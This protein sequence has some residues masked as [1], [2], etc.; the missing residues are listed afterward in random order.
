VEVLGTVQPPSYSNL[1]SRPWFPDAK[2][3][4]GTTT[5]GFCRRRPLMLNRLIRQYRGC[6]NEQSKVGCL[7]E[8]VVV[9][10]GVEQFKTVRRKAA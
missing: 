9:K 1:D 7:G 5:F 3:A 8:T 6:K 10:P 2:S 4:T